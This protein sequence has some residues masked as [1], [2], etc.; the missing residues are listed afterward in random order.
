MHDTQ[1][2]PKPL[3]EVA[4]VH[5]GISYGRKSLLLFFDGIASLETRRESRLSPDS[6]LQSLAELGMLHTFE[7]ESLVDES[8][9]LE[10]SRLIDEAIEVGVLKPISEGE[11]YGAL[12][13]RQRVGHLLAPDIA[14]SIVNNLSSHGLA[15]L[16]RGGSR[17]ELE[18]E[19]FAANG[20]TKDFIHTALTQLVRRPAEARGLFLQPAEWS[21]DP[22]QCQFGRLLCDTQYPSVGQIVSF[23]L[24][25]VTL[26]LEDIP[27][28]EVLDFK[29]QYGAAHRRYAKDLRQF[30][31]ELS[32]TP[33]AQLDRA[34]TERR[35]QLADAADDLR[36]FARKSWQRPLTSFGL[37]MSAAAIAWSQGNQ[38]G[39]GI[40]ALGGILG[41]KRQAEPGSAFTYLFHAQRQLG[42]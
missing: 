39:A 18:M 10:L 27:L 14:E 29:R 28:D 16:L 1:P 24:A 34:L 20:H 25:Q 40:S 26:D 31:L 42:R 19:E 11:I 35:Q 12:V 22:D 33:Q 41:L 15:K 7:A 23:D 17:E 9:A 21:R 32:L 4:F 36:S 30:A 5:G 38:L 8:V 13:D 3:Q 6:L 2:G 37:G